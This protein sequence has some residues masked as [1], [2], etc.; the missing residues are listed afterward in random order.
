MKQHSKSRRPS[1]MKS[2]SPRPI[3]R[4]GA[5]TLNKRIA[6]GGNGEVW[7]AK[8][9]DGSIGAIKILKKLSPKAYQR[10]RDEIQ[11][12]TQNQGLSGVL[13]IL[14][15]NLPGKQS[16]QKPWY[17]MPEAVT[18]EKH[19]VGKTFE[20]IVEVF[21]S[22][23]ESLA[24]LHQKEIKHRDIK[25]GN[26]FALKGQPCFGD[27]G[28]VEYPGKKDVTGRNESMGP[29]WTMAPEMK[30]SGGEADAIKG[31][32]YSFAKTLWIMLTKEWRGFDGLY[33]KA[34]PNSLKTRCPAIYSDPLDKLLL[35]CTDDD[36]A[37]RPMATD[38]VIKLK[39]WLELNKDYEKRNAAEW[40]EVQ[41]QLFPDH[42]PTRAEWQNP[43]TIASIL[44]LIG[45]RESLNHTFF[46]D[47]GGLDI[48]SARVSTAEDG[49]LELEF[50][51]GLY[52]VRPKRLLFENFGADQQWNYFRLESDTLEES[53]VY[54]GIAKKYI[55]EQLVRLA[56]GTCVD[57]DNNSDP[58]PSGARSISRFFSGSFV[59]FQKTSIYNQV[60]GTYDGRHDK[61]SADQFRGYIARS[62][63]ASAAKKQNIQTDPNV[64]LS[65][66]AAAPSA[67]PSPGS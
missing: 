6:E 51:F 59:I 62:V 57:Y 33:L 15:Y 49:C 50:D 29:K 10:F 56:D 13:P 52:I 23:A 26:L 4:L 61:M 58:M 24:V 20:Q 5:W 40:R 21:L 18:L 35:D 54:P 2:R 67:S 31:D 30:R 48:E 17:V 55:N 47:G 12:V 46:P 36:P 65:P 27:F 19:L 34:G 9:S 42:I 60:P 32:I 11:V 1:W 44:T 43:V 37:K 41:Q 38:I 16:G 45:S 64:P 39:E 25:P 14:E 7:L 63:S 66:P 53:G 28:L 8:K 3:Q 22:L